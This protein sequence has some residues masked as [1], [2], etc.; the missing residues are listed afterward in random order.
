M[1]KKVT[2]VLEVESDDDFM[3]S[4]DYIHDELETEI[5]CASNSYDIISIQVSDL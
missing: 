4:D 5:N 2:V 1:K 3:L